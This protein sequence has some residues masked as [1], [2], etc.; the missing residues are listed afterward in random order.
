LRAAVASFSFRSATDCAE[1][2]VESLLGCPSSSIAL[3]PSLGRRLVRLLLRGRQCFM[4]VGQAA[5]S[6]ADLRPPL[7]ASRRSCSLRERRGMNYRHPGSNPIRRAAER[8]SARCPG[9]HSLWQCSLFGES[10][11]SPAA[12]RDIHGNVPSGDA[13]DDVMPVAADLLARPAQR[14]RTAPEQRRT[15]PAGA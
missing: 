11:R 10:E 2:R 5:L 3:A 15:R 13:Q 1:R 8:I 14:T 12:H 4:V 9:I 7:I 6:S